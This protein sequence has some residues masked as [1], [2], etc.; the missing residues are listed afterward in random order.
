MPVPRGAPGRHAD[1]ALFVVVVVRLDLGDGGA[2][3]V[4]DAAN[5]V[6]P[7]RVEVD[8]EQGVHVDVETVR[9]IEPGVRLKSG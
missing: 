8:F 4:G 2:V 1:H 7:R 5:E 9:V 6:V 3:I